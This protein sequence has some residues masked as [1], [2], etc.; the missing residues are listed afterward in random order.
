M[1]NKLLVELFKIDKL[2]KEM[3]II[4]EPYMKNT[5]LEVSDKDI[6]DIN[7]KYGYFKVKENNG[8]ATFAQDLFDET[9]MSYHIRKKYSQEYAMYY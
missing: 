4:K 5:V 9:N 6:E 1:Q 2:K 3:I 7:R 8:I